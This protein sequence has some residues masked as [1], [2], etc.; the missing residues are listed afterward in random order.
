[1]TEIL[2][3]IFSSPRLGL[4][5]PWSF[6]G[7]G[8]H[9]VRGF[10]SGRAERELDSRGWGHGHGHGGS[11]REKRPRLW[12]RRGAFRPFSVCAKPGCAE[13]VELHGSSF[14]A[15]AGPSWRRGRGCE[16]DRTEVELAA[17]AAVHA[18]TQRRENS[19]KLLLVA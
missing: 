2:S 15:G 1:M 11:R 6:G 8:S 13:V 12:R 19:R 4:Q 17:M 3:L 9:K 18:V 14:S 5:I 16:E 7:D 10:E